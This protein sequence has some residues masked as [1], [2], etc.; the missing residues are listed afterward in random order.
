M[1]LAT[2]SNHS[3]SLRPGMDDEKEGGGCLRLRAQLIYILKQ[4]VI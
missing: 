3:H 2:H 1:F 4:I